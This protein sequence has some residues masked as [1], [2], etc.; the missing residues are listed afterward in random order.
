MRRTLLAGSEEKSSLDDV[1]VA[2]GDGVFGL[3]KAVGAVGG[4]RLPVLPARQVFLEQQAG[5]AVMAIREEHAAVE[6]V[7]IGRGDGRFES[8]LR[9]G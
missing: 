9:R 5:P 2:F 4:G 1:A 3:L 8:W 6:L 7:E